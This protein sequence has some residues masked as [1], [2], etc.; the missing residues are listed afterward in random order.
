[1]LYAV[2]YAI[3]LIDFRVE[4]NGWFRAWLFTWIRILLHLMV[5]ILAFGVLIWLFVPV[6]I[7]V[8]SISESFAAIIENICYAIF[9]GLIAACLLAVLFRVLRR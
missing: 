6:M 1:M 3:A 4:P 2:S 8:A 7:G 9:Y 5:P